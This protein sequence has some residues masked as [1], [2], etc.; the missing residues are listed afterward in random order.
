[1]FGKRAS[2]RWYARQDLN[3]RPS[4]SESDALSAAPRARMFDLRR[5][6]RVCFLLF[7]GQTVV[8][9]V[10]L[11]VFAALSASAFNRLRISDTLRAAYVGVRRSIQLSY[12]HIFTFTAIYGIL[13]VVS[14]TKAAAMITAGIIISKLPGKV[15]SGLRLFKVFFGRHIFQKKDILY[16]AHKRLS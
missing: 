9:G 16:E 14:D 4:E 1:M 7:S 15:N 5:L 10:S 11:F 6:A 2:F 8:K 12:G 13:T 3:L